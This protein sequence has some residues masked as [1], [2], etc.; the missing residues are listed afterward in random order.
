[1]VPRL[2]G[3]IAVYTSALL[4]VGVLLVPAAYALPE[5]GSGPGEAG[6]QVD[7]EDHTVSRAYRVIAPA[8]EV[9]TRGVG[10]AVWVEQD[11]NRYAVHGAYQSE[12]GRWSKGRRISKAFSWGGRLEGLPGEPDVTVDDRG[13]ATVVWA[14]KVGRAVKIHTAQGRKN[15][16]SPPRSIS[17]NNDVGMYPEVAVSPNGRHALASWTGNYLTVDSM[18]LMASTRTRAGTWTKPRQAIPT[19]GTYK[20]SSRQPPPV[21][22]NHGTATVAWVEVER[23]P[24]PEGFVYGRIQSATARRG[25]AW[26]PEELYRGVPGAYAEN[27]SLA[28]SP[29]GELLVAIT[30][31]G[32]GGQLWIRR[33]SAGGAWATPVTAYQPSPV[34]ALQAPIAAVGPDGRGVVVQETFTQTGPQSFTTQHL[35]VLEDALG[36]GWHA[37]TVSDP[38]DTTGVGL[39]TAPDVA[40]GPKGDIAV[41]WQFATLD[42]RGLPATVRHRLPDGR[43]LDARSLGRFSTEPL[44]A[45]D[46]RGRMRA[47]WSQGRWYVDHVNCCHALKSKRL[48]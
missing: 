44:L 13:R 14:Q 47:L 2:S 15:H 21:I 11:G 42:P 17:G 10:Y 37:E 43:W 22:D 39:E 20:P 33:R 19:D 12:T 35:L 18:T 41:G 27:V 29:E 30:I 7:D 28:T 25:G 16:W 34:T 3:R 8:Y 1:M 45:I 4:V 9:N 32:S 24:T 36:G 26:V 5:V 46:T 38:V 31:G 6:R 23:I 48:P 40:V